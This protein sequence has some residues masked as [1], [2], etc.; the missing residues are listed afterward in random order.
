MS[1]AL[2]IILIIVIVNNGH[3]KDEIDEL[4]KHNYN[5]CPK[6]GY[7]LNKNHQCTNQQVQTVPQE[8][9]NNLETKV[10]KEITK[11]PKN[12]MTD[13]E[14]KN[15]IILIT[16][17]ILI[18]L[19]AVIYLTSSWTV[20][21]NILKCLVIFIL[22]FV[23]VISSYIAKEKLKL[24]QTAR[25]FK[26]I[27]LAYLPLSLIS[28]SLFGLLGENFSMNGD[29][30]NFYIAITLFI[31]SIIYYIESRREKDMFL[32]ISTIISSILGIVF[33]VFAFNGSYI[34]LIMFLY[35]YSYF[36]ALLYEYN[37]VIYDKEFTK[38]IIKIL[39]Y[40]LLCVLVIMNINI[41]FSEDLSLTTTYIVQ[42][43]VILLLN[44]G[45]SIYLDNKELNR[46]L[47]PVSIILVFNLIR[48]LGDFSNIVQQVIVMISITLIYGYNYLKEKKI[49]VF[50]FILCSILLS[51]LFFVNLFTF[52]GESIPLFVISL[53]YV[54]LLIVTYLISGNLRKAI[55]WMLPIFIEFTAILLVAE[56]ELSINILLGISTLLVVSSLIPIF[57]NYTKEL[58][59]IPSVLNVIYILIAYSD[60]SLITF[61]LTVISLVVYYLLFTKTNK[62]YKYP[63]YLFIN[64]GMI[65]LG[66]IVCNGLNAYTMALSIIIIM[67]LEVIDE[68][69]KDKG[70]FIFILTDYIITAIYL[71]SVDKR[72]AFI[73]TIIIALV[74]FAY[75]LDNKKNIELYNIPLLTPLIYIGTSSVMTFNE[76][77]VMIVL[78]I[79]IAILIPF[80]VIYKKEYI[81]LAFVPYAYLLMLCS[82]DISL[83]FPYVL[84]LCI[85]IVYLI[86]T[87]KHI[88]FKILTI[89][90][91][92]LLYYKVITDLEITITLFT[93]GILILYSLFI[94]RDLMKEQPNDSKVIEYILLIIINIIAITSYKSETDG[95]LYVIL[96]LIITIFSYLKKYGPAF[97]VSIVFI[98]INMFLLTRLFWLSLPWWIYILGVGLILILFAVLNEINEKG[99]MKEKLKDFKDRL[100]M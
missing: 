24:S 1:L 46:V 8:T 51:V 50:N 61:I 81:K 28:L 76:F 92:L 93:I 80:L 54:V 17:S 59:I 69:L 94:T 14:V 31:C 73:M 49:N 41:I 64:L 44:V 74:L 42:N 97:L 79:L 35:L 37:K 85:S 3:L 45:L 18:I 99:T 87:D 56:Y 40:S 66:H 36:L 16:G 29:Y 48:S 20:T 84:A 25:A 7:Q 71:T 27:A 67:A 96:L 57:K 90:T 6:C 98:L 10:N 91:S 55:V 100:N 11:S 47:I 30:Q 19:A 15:N 65:Y 22:F 53:I 32:S 12:T 58:V 77:N 86:F 72:T 70:N 5:Y 9:N 82:M 2:L 21:S 78:A 26:Y 13:E 75:F 83:Y 88:L 34:I 89:I 43:I 52:L 4:K 63:M 23:F 33:L 60:K 38:T 62:N 95:M 68:R 39:F